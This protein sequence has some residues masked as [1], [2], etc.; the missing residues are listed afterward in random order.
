[1]PD[2]IW[3]ANSVVSGV[4]ALS[5]NGNYVG[6]VIMPAKAWQD[7]T[8]RLGLVQGQDGVWRSEES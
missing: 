3:E 2:M 6:R 5:V 4:Y 7:F 1:M 8:A